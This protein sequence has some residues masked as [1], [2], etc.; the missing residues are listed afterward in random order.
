LKIAEKIRI[1]SGSLVLDEPNYNENIGRD[2]ILFKDL[3]DLNIRCV[4]DNAEASFSNQAGLNEVRDSE[5]S[6][7]PMVV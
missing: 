7:L 5:I 6:L 3:I 2:L 1:I 4:P